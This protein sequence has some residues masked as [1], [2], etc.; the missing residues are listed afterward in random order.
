MTAKKKALHLFQANRN[1]LER[2]FVRYATRRYRCKAQ[3]VKFKFKE[4]I[5]QLKRAT[6]SKCGDN[7]LGET[8]GSK[9][10][11]SKQMQMSQ[12]ELVAVLLHE[13]LHNFCVV[14]G[15][16]MSCNNEHRCMCSLGV[17]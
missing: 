16:F 11:I 4:Q 9:I 13:A 14:R 8:D 10:Y 6:L 7:N 5:A 1:V 15:K 3:Q 2:H 12:N 17:Y